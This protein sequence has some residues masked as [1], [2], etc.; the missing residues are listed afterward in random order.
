MFIFKSYKKQ[1][2]Y[3]TLTPDRIELRYS[4]VNKRDVL[5]G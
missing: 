4:K 2:S 1:S 5:L 3:G